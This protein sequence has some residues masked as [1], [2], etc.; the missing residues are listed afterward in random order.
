MVRQGT[1]QRRK[2][3]SLAEGH[4]TR[5]ALITARAKRSGQQQANEALAQ[6]RKDRRRRTAAL[7][8]IERE[9]QVVTTL[10]AIP[11]RSLRALG[12]PANAGVLIAEGDSWFDY[13]LTD[14]LRSLEDDYG[15]DVESVAHK[16]DRVEDMAFSKGQLEQF[17]RRLEKLLRNQQVPKAI[18]LSGGGNDI[19]GNEF[20]VLLNHA[21]SPIAG[22]N[23][24]I[25]AGV[26]DQRIRTSYTTIIA[27]I[28]KICQAYLQRTIPILT[29]GY[30]YAV[31]D[32][33]GFLG[34]FSFLP[35]PWLEPGFREKGFSDQTENAAIVRKLM[36]RFNQMLKAASSTSG[37]THVKYIDL[38][39]T[40]SDSA[41]Y[42]TYWSNELHPTKRG[43]RMV[44]AKFAKVI[45]EL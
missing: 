41:D 13:P 40:L 33:R 4:S 36:D 25:V 31:P 38:R 39:G 42:K 9:R 45:A 15:F 24:D 17:T 7:K 44:A 22:L 18:L 28:T 37:F 29:H 10:P 19:A 21:A 5:I 35:G 6:R 2:R 3:G 23:A 20:G 34:G 1:R 26:I 43:F 27:A 16:G 32:G 12:P 11:I 30:D 14:V 8:R